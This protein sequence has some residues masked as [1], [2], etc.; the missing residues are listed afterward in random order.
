MLLSEVRGV[1][2]GCVIDVPSQLREA[3]MEKIITCT[4]CEK[5][6]KVSGPFGTTNPAERPLSALRRN[7]RSDVAN[8]IGLHN[9]PETTSTEIERNKVPAM[10]AKKVTTAR[11]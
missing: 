6:F 2:P 5:T 7:E 3:Y 8:G 4:H 11:R 9:D 1:E 10:P